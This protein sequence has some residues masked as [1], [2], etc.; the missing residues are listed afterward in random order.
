MNYKLLRL[1]V[2]LFTVLCSGIL[3]GEVVFDD[4]FDSS[5]L[6]GWLLSYDN[7]DT[8]NCSYQVSDS[9]IMLTNIAPT[10]ENLWTSFGLRR[11][12]DNVGDFHLRVD[13]LWQQQEIVSAPFIKVLLYSGSEVVLSLNYE[14]NSKAGFGVCRSYSYP[15]GFSLVNS[16]PSAQ[17]SAVWEADRVG[18]DIAVKLNGEP[19]FK[20]TNS[21]PITLVRVYFQGYAFTS[22]SMAWSWQPPLTIGLD[23]I[24]LFDQAQ[25]TIPQDPS[26][27]LPTIFSDNMILQQNEPAPLWG[28]APAA[29]DVTVSLGDSQWQTTADNNGEWKI[30]LPPQQ[31]G[32]DSHRIT[33]TCGDE[34]VELNDVLFGEVWLCSGQSNME[35]WLGYTKEAQQALDS[36]PDDYLRVFSV[37][38][39][40][41]DT[42]M[43]DPRGR[44]LSCSRDTVGDFSAIAYQLGLYFKEQLNVP[45]GMVVAAWGGTRAECWMNRELLEEDFPDLIARWEQ[46][47]ED[48]DPDTMDYSLNPMLAYYRPGG[49]YNGMIEPVMGYAFKGFV[50]YQGESNASRAQEYRTLFPALIEQWRRDWASDLPFIFVQLPNYGTRSDEPRDSEWAELRDAQNQALLL[51]KVGMA[52][53]I[54]IG[55][56][57]NIHPDNKPETARRLG[58]EAL[59]IAYG[60]E[61]L[62]QSPRPNAETASRC[63]GS[64]RLQFAPVGEQGLG[65]SGETNS[66]AGFTVC[67]SDGVFYKAQ[68]QIVDEHTVIV[69]SDQVEQPVEMRYAWDYN[70][71]AQLID[72]AGGLPVGTFRIEAA[73]MGKDLTSDVNKDCYIDINDWQV[74]S[75]QWLETNDPESPEATPLY[76]ETEEQI[77]MHD[78]FA[79]GERNTQ[80]LPDSA[81]WLKRL[82][83][84]VTVDTSSADYYM[85]LDDCTS[86]QVWAH[87]TQPGSPITLGV[88]DSLSFVMRLS[89]P[90]AADTS[91]NRALMFGLFNSMGTRDTVDYTGTGAQRSDDSGYYAETNPGR[92]TMSYAKIQKMILQEGSQYNDHFSFYETLVAFSSFT[93][94]QGTGYDVEFGVERTSETSLSIDAKAGPGY[95]VTGIVDVPAEQRYFS[96]DTISI[97]VDGRAFPGDLGRL[98]VDKVLLSHNWRTSAGSCAE[99][100]STGQRMPADINS[101][102]YVNFEDIDILASQWLECQDFNNP[103]CI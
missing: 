95:Y 57:D 10:G 60:W 42:P 94:Q 49:L 67:G 39:E 46:D 101:D 47:L 18:E 86:Q 84:A 15:D 26:L 100:I 28:K 58:L 75:Q 13:A 83:G 68:C 85:H 89:L 37:Y 19:F 55:E 31:G 71:I 25:N 8:E 92:T 87:F 96:F 17:G 91:W 41:S 88:G 45:V 36:A 32:F 62:P 73:D 35:W 33:V 9:K 38:K 54:D 65:S 98:T 24:A 77:L 72:K 66:P 44:W 23:R 102:C 53:T 78:E 80:L 69:W 63:S 21:N 99:V 29:S 97:F 1:S 27:V 79:D 59:K 11:Y 2:V 7:T 22:S 70:P 90:V 48:Y 56:A 3:Y 61:N 93:M 16:V 50:W 103:L 51:D 4:D 52:V 6:E 43:Y 74:L 12:V 34:F 81:K 40:V 14:D 5:A 30:T 20:C 76:G 82:S 64:I